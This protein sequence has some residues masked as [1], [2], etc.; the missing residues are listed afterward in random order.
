[1]LIA[2]GL[3]HLLRTIPDRQVM[4]GGALFLITGLSLGFFV[5]SYAWLLPLWGVLN[6]NLAKPSFSE[7]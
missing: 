6:H 2:L 5:S 4:L 1:M 7:G 3:P